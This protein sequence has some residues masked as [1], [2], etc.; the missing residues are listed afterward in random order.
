MVCISASRKLPLGSQ[1]N[2]RIPCFSTQSS[3]EHGNLAPEGQEVQ[4]QKWQNLEEQR[5][6][7][8]FAQTGTGVRKIGDQESPTKAK[9]GSER[10]MGITCSLPEWE[11]WGTRW[12]NRDQVPCR[13][14]REQ[15]LNEPQYGTFMAAFVFFILTPPAKVYQQIQAELES[16][17]VGFGGC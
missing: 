3:L 10:W 5:H 7:R 15:F 1:K 2:L 13:T 17:P 11:W 14:V 4:N 16:V 6:R 8:A 9:A 12:A